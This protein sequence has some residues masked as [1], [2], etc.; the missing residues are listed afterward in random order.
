LSFLVDVEHDLGLDFGQQVH[1]PFE[2]DVHV[3]EL[4]RGFIVVV[5]VVLFVLH[6]RFS[7]LSFL[8]SLVV[9]FVFVEL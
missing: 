2:T 9:V 3:F 4:L 8:L 5:D 1:V 6:R 7:F